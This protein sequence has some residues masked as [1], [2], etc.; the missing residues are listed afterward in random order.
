MSELNNIYFPTVGMNMY[1][2]NVSGVTAAK[3]FSIFV[4]MYCATRLAVFVGY[5]F[6][7]ICNNIHINSQLKGGLKGDKNNNRSK[8][9]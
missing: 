8:T 9:Q 5:S 3:V 2:E 6:I 7:A 1:K 4:G